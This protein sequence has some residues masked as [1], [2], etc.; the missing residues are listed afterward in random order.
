MNAMFGA[1]TSNSAGWTG[2]AQHLAAQAQLVTLVAAGVLLLI[3]LLVGM[4]RT[5]EEMGGPFRSGSLMPVVG[6]S[7]WSS[8]YGVSDQTDGAL[9]PVGVATER[10]TVHVL[11][12]PSGELTPTER[13]ALAALRDRVWERDIAD[14][15]TVAQRLAFARW[16]VEHGRLEG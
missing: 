2:M 14:G 7:S 16:L 1:V 11:R 5:S 15:R 12:A 4:F 13:G 8:Q 6:L 3:L 9:L 10:R